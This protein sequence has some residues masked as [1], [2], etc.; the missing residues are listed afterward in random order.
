M[1]GKPLRVL[2]V[3]N[4]NDENPS[5][6]YRNR[7]VSE[8]LNEMGHEVFC[9]THGN[10][11]DLKDYD[12]VVFNRFYEGSLENEL[13]NLRSY[14]KK[15]VYETDDNYFAMDGHVPFERAKRF[16]VPSA[17]EL[18]KHAD[19]ISV[20]TPYLKGVY[21]KITKT[22]IKVIPNALNFQD[23]DMRPRERKELRIG[24]QGS[25]VHIGDLLMV[26]KP[27]RKLQKK[28]KFK[29]IIFGIDDQPIEDLHEFAKKRM[30]GREWSVNL[31]KLF[32]YIEEMK[33]EGLFEHIPFTKY[34]E[35][36]QIKLPMLDFDIGICPLMDTEFNRAKSC[37][38]YYEYVATGT[39][40]LA[41]NVIPYNTE[42]KNKDL[43][44]NTEEE[45]EAALEKLITDDAYRQSRWMMQN[46]WVRSKRSINRIAKEWETFYKLLK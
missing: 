43:V 33:A 11:L 19:L 21:E 13:A 22:P 25:N 44:N 14:G 36:Y 20:S 35:Q 12:I 40:A 45:W 10:E 4:T 37:L 23:Y 24:W 27:I 17:L 32:P 16:S 38:K 7:I 3:N 2:V 42:M 39:T 1:E 8:A 30:D 5:Y 28:Y 15:I 29:F 18:A 9:Q 31:E 6:F 26:I 46:Q 41:S 34:V